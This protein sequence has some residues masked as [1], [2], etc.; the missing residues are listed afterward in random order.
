MGFWETLSQ[1][2]RWPGCELTAFLQLMPSLSMNTDILAINHMLKLN[3]TFLYLLQLCVFT[4]SPKSIK[5][6][7][8]MYEERSLSIWSGT[9]DKNTNLQYTYCS[10]QFLWTFPFQLSHIHGV[11][12]TSISHTPWYKRTLQPSLMQCIR[13]C[14]T[15]CITDSS[16]SWQVINRRKTWVRKILLEGIC[17]QYTVIYGLYS[18]GIMI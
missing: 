6:W 12:C 8:L 10:M 17:N 15:L 18:M 11:Y 1:G 4:R 5:F 2:L 14:M 16:S 13:R 3:L 9:W 7:V